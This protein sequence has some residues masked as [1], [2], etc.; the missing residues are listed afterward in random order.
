MCR[1]DQVNGREAQR[2]SGSRTCTHNLQAID[3]LACGNGNLFQE[4]LV[5]PEH[6]GLAFIK[7]YGG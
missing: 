3:P 7:Q 4:V 2:A 6:E 5:K 1:Q